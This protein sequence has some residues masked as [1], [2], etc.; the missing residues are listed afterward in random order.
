MVVVP[1]DPVKIKGIS[2]VVELA[3]SGNESGQL[4]S[5]AQFPG[6]PGKPP[7]ET[8]PARPRIRLPG[9]RIAAE[10]RNGTG[11]VTGHSTGF[12]YFSGSRAIT[13]EVITSVA[14]TSGRI[15]TAVLT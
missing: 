12:A 5:R 8:S 7:G 13:S 4:G 6:D 15:C 2:R 3:G 11:L 9:I 1:I 10:H 14:A